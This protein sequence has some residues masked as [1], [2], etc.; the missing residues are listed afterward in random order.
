MAEEKSLACH[1]DLDGRGQPGNALLQDEGRSHSHG[2]PGPGGVSLTRAGA[3]ERSQAAILHWSSI[4]WKATGSLVSFFLSFLLRTPWY[5]QVIA[6]LQVA[7]RILIH[8]RELLPSGFHLSAE[9]A[10]ASPWDSR[11]LGITGPGH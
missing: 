6:V 4:P 7:G 10:Q 8:C 3:A 9:G 5:D 1:A 11:H 2:V